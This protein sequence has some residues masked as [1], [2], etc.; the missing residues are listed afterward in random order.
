MYVDRNKARLIS[1]IN[2]FFRH[3]IWM[4][5]YDADDWWRYNEYLKE[6]YTNIEELKKHYKEQF[7]YFKEQIDE[8]F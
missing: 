2:D 7:K 8:T 1:R 5:E 4:L 6:R 3:E